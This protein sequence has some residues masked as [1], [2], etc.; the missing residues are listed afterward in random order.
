MYFSSFSQLWFLIPRFDLVLIC[1]SLESF[2]PI[3]MFTYIYPFFKLLFLDDYE[4]QVS[5]CLVLIMKPLFCGFKR[6][7]LLA[8]CPKI[9]C[10]VSLP[11][12][13]KD[14]TMPHRFCMS[15]T[16]LCININ[17]VIIFWWFCIR[18]IRNVIWKV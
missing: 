18:C 17:T 4:V 1:N 16:R 9:A 14:P 12:Y 6:M 7:P 11:K 2:V 3:N 15:T 8:L 5:F 10:Q 13:S